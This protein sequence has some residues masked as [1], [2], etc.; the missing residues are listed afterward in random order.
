MWTWKLKC[1]YNL[2]K[3]SVKKSIPREQSN[4]NEEMKI[5]DPVLFCSWEIMKGATSL[6]LP[7][8]GFRCMQFAMYWSH[9]SLKTRK[10]IT[11]WDEVGAT[12]ASGFCWTIF[13]I[14]GY[15]HANNCV[16]CLYCSSRMSCCIGVGW[17]VVMWRQYWS[18]PLKLLVRF[19]SLVRSILVKSHLNLLLY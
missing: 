12:C 19:T 11:N 1:C 2:K 5:A 16:V 3:K 15:I 6:T 14:L 4:Q 8:I 7:S 17:S 18:T 13:L 10:N 9:W